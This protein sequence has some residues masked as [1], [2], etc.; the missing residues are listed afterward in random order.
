MVRWGGSTWFLVGVA[1]LLA[2]LSYILYTP[3]PDG[4]SQPWKLQIFMA[5]VKLAGVVSEI[6][7]LLGCG[8]RNNMTRMIFEKLVGTGVVSKSD[9][10]LYVTDELFDGVSVRIYYPRA[11]KKPLPC[12]VYYHGGG[13]VWM[14]VNSYDGVAAVYAKGAKVAVVS[15]EYRLAPEYPYPIPFEDCRKATMFLLKNADD[16]DIDPT[17]IA[18]GGDSSGG[19][20][21]AAL[22]VKFRDD[23]VLPRIRRQILIYP[24]LQF[25]DARLPVHVE[26]REFSP[27]YAQQMA[28]IFGM[29][30][31]LTIDQLSLMATGN[32]STRS[33]RER[34]K[35]CVDY[36]LLP[37]HMVPRDY[38]RHDLIAP[39]D[40][41]YAQDI[42]KLVSDPKI[43]PL[44]TED[45]SELPPAFILTVKVDGLRD[46]GIIY[47][48]RLE[49][50]G[51]RVK[52]MHLPDTFHGV[53]NFYRGIFGFDAAQRGQRYIIEYLSKNI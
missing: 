4:V 51:V 46:E 33:L 20:I 24:I 15:V 43:A 23:Q 11:A 27:Y 36:K 9:P 6:G 35:R 19:N 21:A 5:S 44:M 30:V 53:L 50:A 32:F 49:Q 3:V 28:F 31:N 13:F 1:G 52:W 25:C 48:K 10:E 7:H 38:K 45:L 14:S 26:Q 42:E 37:H 40:N 2:G 12:L 16:F 29:Y 47:A 17:R 34:C 39:A 22:A 8:S 18:I 41:P